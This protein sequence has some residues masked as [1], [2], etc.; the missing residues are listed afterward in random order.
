MVKDRILIADDETDIA[1]I[2]KLQLEDAGY[3]TVRVKDG[4]DALDM[5]AKEEFELLLLDIK[6]PRMD[7]LQVL[8]RV[9]DAY[10]AMVVVMMTAHGS[11]DI[12]VQAMKEGAVDYIAKPFSNDDMIKR[13]ER[14]IFYNRTLLDN[15]RLQEQLF[16]EQQKTEAILQGMAELL[17]AVD[18]KGDIISVNRM[19][20]NLLGRKREEM[21]GK[22]VET[23]LAPELPAGVA[24][25]SRQTL[26]S[27]EPSLDVTYTLNTM[28]GRIPV[29]ASAAPL[30][31]NGGV[32]IGS[33]EIIRDISSLKALEREREDFV[34]M[35]S[36]DL[37][38][39]ITS[40]VGSLDL[41]REGRLG[42]INADQCEFIEA[43]EESCAEMVEM[44]NSL[45]DIH[46]FEAGR[47]VMT[48]RPEKVQHLIPKLAAQYSTAAE[49][50]GV[51]LEFRVAE[52]LPE[53]SLDRT[54]FIRL[55]GNLLTNALK[56]TPEKGSIT[57]S[58][59]QLATVA[60]ITGS[61]PAGLYHESVASLAGPCLRIV[62]ADSGVGIPG[63]A[64]GTI[65]D[66]F[67]QAQNRREGKSRGTGLG[68]AFCRKVMDAHHGLIWAESE[69]GKG[70][71]F[72]ALFPLYNDD[73]E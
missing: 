23:V 72:T 56:F 37:K 36:H 10:P 53:C 13:V 1:L 30:H 11:E 39:P 73:T 24:L 52:N 63:D 14:A 6:M 62:V 2:L 8:K 49:K 44:I 55:I 34:S 25:P 38:N 19:A 35:L 20:E 67:V 69:E 33:V 60:P 5:L 40:I 4:V 51:T 28:T 9:R 46:K 18:D 29:L 68:L 58:V 27:G 32:L 31:D 65:F 26:A 59:D 41:V 15:Q 54:T 22:Q 57:V 42:P 12:A 16:A 70:S 45:L 7:G 71:R 17:V 48:F 64:L 47:M 3:T 43:A 21:L 50:N 66:R 61:I